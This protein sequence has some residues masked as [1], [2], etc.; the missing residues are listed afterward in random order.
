MSWNHKTTDMKRCLFITM[1]RLT[2]PGSL[3]DLLS[4]IKLPT[5]EILI[6]ETCISIL[7]SVDFCF[8]LLIFYNEY[9]KWW[10]SLWQCYCTIWQY[11]I[12]QKKQ[13]VLSSSLLSSPSLT[14]SSLFLKQSSSCVGQLLLDMRHIMEYVWYTQVGW[15]SL[16]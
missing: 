12:S 1:R 9:T 13:K 2:Q 8:N 7:C 6:N 14:S 4:I 3:M 15:D 11:K 5:P 16:L 10:I